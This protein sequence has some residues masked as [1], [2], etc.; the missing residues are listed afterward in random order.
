MNYE[1]FCIFVCWSVPQFKVE[2]TVII[3]L[4]FYIASNKRESWNLSR[5]SWLEDLL[6]SPCVWQTPHETKPKFMSYCLFAQQAHEPIKRSTPLL[7]IHSNLRDTC[8]V[9][10]IASQLLVGIIEHSLHRRSKS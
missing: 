8:V 10:I 5:L 2:N 4:N 9:A 7:N 1:P 6:R 3:M